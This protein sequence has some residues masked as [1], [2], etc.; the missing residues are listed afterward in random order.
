[1]TA[2]VLLKKYLSPQPARSD[3]LDD[4]DRSPDAAFYI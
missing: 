2:A 4:I 1:M 3:S